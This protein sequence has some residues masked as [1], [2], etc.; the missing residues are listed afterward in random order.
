NDNGAITFAEAG[1]GVKQD[2]VVAEGRIS[3]KAEGGD[4]VGLRE[5]GF[6]EGLDIGKD[7]RVFIARGG[8]LVGG[9]GIKHEGVVGIG[10]VGKLDLAGFLLGLGCRLS[11][12][13]RDKSSSSPG[14]ARRVGSTPMRRSNEKDRWVERRRDGRGF[15]PG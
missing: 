7:V 2:V 1:A 3:G 14:E 8:E 9:Q 11:S 10:R 6:V 4:V 15:R 12:S 13:H 5:S